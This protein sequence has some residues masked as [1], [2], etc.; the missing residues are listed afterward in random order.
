M[1]RN[2]TGEG[3]VDSDLIADLNDLIQLDADAAEACTVAAENLEDE[4][5]RETLQSIIS[6][7]QLHTSDL[8]DLVGEL[9]GTPVPLGHLS[10][11]PLKRAV[12]ALGAAAGDTQNLLTL[13]ANEAQVRDKYH[14]YAE[15]PY[16]PRVAEVLRR[17]T[18]EEEEHYARLSTV[19]DRIGAGA[20]TAVGKAAGAAES[21]YGRIADTVEAL[22][23]KGFEKL[24]DPAH[25]GEDRGSDAVAAERAAELRRQ[26]SGGR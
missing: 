6:D 22:E 2:E 13:K 15:R 7:H 17:I 25:E 16:P 4:A 10:T 24:A 1:T 14:R 26:S 21:V 3:T 18:A 8:F 12:Q 23:R 5:Y 9:G 19:L 20:D 11:G